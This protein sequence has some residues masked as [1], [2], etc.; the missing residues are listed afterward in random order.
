MTAHID[1]RFQRQLKEPAP[2]APTPGTSDPALPTQSSGVVVSQA[3]QPVGAPVQAE[4]LK[5]VVKRL[6]ESIQI[7]RRDLHFSYDES[8]GRTVITV[9]NS[10]TGEIVRQIP[11][12]EVLSLAENLEEMRGVL[13]QAKA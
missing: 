11:P 10:D 1:S 3:A 6:N 9:I 8:A 12:E 13:F 5:G 4:E 2:V 7:V